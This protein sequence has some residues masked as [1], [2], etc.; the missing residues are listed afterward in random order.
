MRDYSDFA[1]KQSDFFKA[2]T[3]G[4]DN[5]GGSHE[6]LMLKVKDYPPEAAFADEMPRHW[7]V[8][9]YCRRAHVQPIAQTTESC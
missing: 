3:N 6:P 9:L 4:G 5:L 1:M 8:S 2:F 7:Q